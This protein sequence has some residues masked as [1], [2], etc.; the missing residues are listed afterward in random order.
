[1][2]L[3]LGVV[4]VSVLGGPAFA[5]N[6]KCWGDGVDEPGRP[7]ISCTEL[8]EGLLLSL[9]GATKAEVLRAMNA[10]GVPDNGGVL[11]FVSNYAWRQRSGVGVVDFHFGP[12]GQ[13]EVINATVD[14]SSGKKGMR[15]VWNATL[16][17]C[18]DFSGSIQRCDNHEGAPRALQPVASQAPIGGG[19]WS[20]LPS[21]LFPR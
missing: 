12:D 16:G 20:W 4:L 17:S 2:R 14:A 21:W 18:S 6:A 19:V 15:F 13:V 1:M 11:H 9:E 8:T 3:W 5:D 10:P 7:D